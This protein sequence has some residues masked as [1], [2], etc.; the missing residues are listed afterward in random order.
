MVEGDFRPKAEG[1]K[2]SGVE[3]ISV[4][5][6][7]G[8][9]GRRYDGTR[10]NA[11]FQVVNALANRFGVVLQERKF[12]AQWAEAVVEGRKVLF[13]K[14]TTYMNRSGDAVDAMLQYFK[15]PHSR[16]LV[17]HDDLDMPLGRVKIVRAGGAGGH[18][19]VASII[20]R[21]G[22]GGFARLKL[23][24]GRPRHGEPVEVYVLRGPEEDERD[25]F[26]KMVSHGAEAARAVLERGLEAAMNLYNTRDAVAL[27]GTP[28]RAETEA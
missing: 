26:E 9:P 6:G 15:M 5:V 19:G 25:R 18:R 12:P 16:M 22:D 8:N 10:H 3:R 23:G 27:M 11:G 4:V 7:L 13:I 17:I 24:I 14:P 2:L 28:V 1:R 20:E 21:V